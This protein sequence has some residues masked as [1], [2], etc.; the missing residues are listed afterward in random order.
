VFL[1]LRMRSVATE[2]EFLR[3]MLTVRMISLAEDEFL[4]VR[5]KSLTR[6]DEFFKKI[7]WPL[8]MRPYIQG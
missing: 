1:A 7:F 2:D 4:A 8:R 6:E 5:M 3:R